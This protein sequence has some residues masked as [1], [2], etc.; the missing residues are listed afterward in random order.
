MKNY[1][2]LLLFIGFFYSNE[3]LSAQGI[4]KGQILNDDAEAMSFVNVLLLNAGDSVFVHGA[5]TN[6]DGEYLFEKLKPG[7]YLISA[8][9]VG[10]SQ[11]YRPVP[12]LAENKT[13]VTEP[14][15]LSRGI[16]LTGV[17]VIAKK[18]LYEQKID[19]LVVN[20]ENSIVSAGAS[21]LEILERSPGVVV[22]R[23]NSNI[24]L[25]G[26]NGVNVMINGKVS[27]LPLSSLI[28]FLEG[29]SADNIK[30]IELITT[31]PA[32]FDAEGNAGFINIVLKKRTDEGVNGSYS[33][34]YGYGRG[35]V[36]NNN[37]NLNFRK[38]KLNLFGSYSFVLGAR[39]QTFRT[40]RTI[41]APNSID[42]SFTNSL[43]EPTQRNHNVRLGI[44]YQLSDKT[45]IGGQVTGYDNKWTLDALSINEILTNELISTVNSIQINERNQW[46]HYSANLNFKHN[47]TDQEFISFD[48]DYLDFSNENPTTYDNSIFNGN[49]TFLLEELTQSSKI[50][51]INIQVGKVDYKNEISD[52]FNV[53]MGLKGVRS[54]FDNNVLVQ[55]KD[56]SNWVTDPS[57][58]SNSQLAENILAAYTSADLKIGDKTSLKLGLRYE[59]TNSKLD[60]DSDGRV[61]D[62]Q[63]GRLFPSA[64][65]NHS[66]N[67]NFS[68][69]LSYSRRITRPTFNEMAPFVFLLD[70]TTFFAGNVKIQ[71]SFTDAV[72]LDLR[73]KSL[74]FS[75]QYAFQDSTI[76]RFQQRY[77][78]ETGR[79]ILLSENL[80]NSKVLSFTIG[81]PLEVT[82]WWQMQTNAIYF[83]RENNSYIQ[84][85]PIRLQQDYFQVNTTQS[86]KLPLGF[87]SEISFFYIG[88]RISGTLEFEK[89]Y[90]INLGVQKKLGDKW[91]R[92]R[93]N[94]NDILNSQ[95][96]RASAN[97]DAQNLQYNGIFDFSQRTFILTY[98]K[99]FGNRK[100][101]AK[102]NRV[103]GAEEE[104]RRVN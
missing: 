8:T 67:D 30:S 80:K 16:T 63:F 77:D 102:R 93:F 101:K 35:E 90:G 32:S 73:Y 2:L 7:S 91:G 13:L 3:K 96:L 60:T 89:I 42:Q 49:N 40:N 53:E 79:L 45:I 103:S 12:H 4:I 61:I 44:D 11:V 85:Q 36:S 37:I 34:S 100:M 66:F 26:K 54:T 5:I 64:F 10:Y 86:L 99:N 38:N 84:E 57:L 47:F 25:V 69:N 20:V 68:S 33:L 24:S 50:T 95:E 29:I 76:A 18:P 104:R 72:K 92:L 14:I 51:P 1:I 52:K 94:L 15:V 55:M 74:F 21:A 98:S 43:R 28:Q 41:F 56:G 62:R 58:S 70:P 65:I 78:S 23:Q 39:E 59:Y 97:V 82:K 88:P 31:P 87:S 81:Y 27:Y 46:Q 71:P 83:R 19:R 75:A 6:D 22:D 17:E 9:M 48:L